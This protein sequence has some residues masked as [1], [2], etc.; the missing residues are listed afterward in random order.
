MDKKIIIALI[1][2]IVIIII[3]LLIFMMR[4]PW[5]GTWVGSAGASDMH[6][7][8]NNGQYEMKNQAGV[9]IGL[10]ISGN[11][12]RAF[13]EVGKL[14]GNKITWSNNNVWTKK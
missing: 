7:I 4:D 5:V 6:T 1:V 12:I 14:N 9:A 2:L 13:N 3:G 11:E 8:T 10:T